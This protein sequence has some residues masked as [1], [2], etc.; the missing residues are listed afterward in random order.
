MREA[1]K[2]VELRAKCL[3]ETNRESE[4]DQAVATVWQ[5]I[6]ESG[7]PE[8]ELLAAVTAGR[9][10]VERKDFSSRAQPIL[11][12][13]MSTWMTYGTTFATSGCPTLLLSFYQSLLKETNSTAQLREVSAL[14][15]A[16]LASDR[17][18][19][20]DKEAVDNLLGQG[21]ARLETLQYD[22]A[23]RCF[24]QALS[25][26]A[27]YDKGTE[28]GKICHRAIGNIYWKRGQYKQAEEHFRQCVDNVVSS[29]LPVWP[30]LNQLCRLLVEARRF[31]AAEPLIQRALVLAEA[32]S[33]DVQT[34]ESLVLWK[35]TLKQTGRIE[36]ADVVEERAKSMGRKSG[37]WLEQVPQ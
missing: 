32:N 30:D 1:L 7:N 11:R 34:Y 16:T 10:F 4:A 6:S 35:E 2:S 12:R 31:T 27:K 33:N 24:D 22:A 3:V 13:G 28:L 25:I 8:G 18:P 14:L 19:A 29:L 36:L 21:A 15:A 26:T 9:Y 20:N 17:L 5:R 37:H 23:M